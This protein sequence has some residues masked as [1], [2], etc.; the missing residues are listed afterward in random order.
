MAPASNN[1][2]GALRREE[3]RED[4]AGSRNLIVH[5]AYARYYNDIII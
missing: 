1:N 5:F 4:K 3:K 2:S